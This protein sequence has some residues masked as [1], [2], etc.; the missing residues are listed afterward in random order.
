MTDEKYKMVNNIPADISV[1]RFATVRAQEIVALTTMIENPQ[2]TKLIFQKL[3]CHMRRRAMSHNP[4]RMP[5]ALR[6]AHK[7]Q[8]AKSGPAL[9]P[10]RPRRK[11]RRRPSRLL[12]EY[13]KRSNKI[14]WL[15]TH[16]WHAKRF[17]MTA[18][19]GYRLPEKSCARG[20]RFCYRSVAEHCILL[21]ISY[22][23]CIEIQGPQNAIIDGLAPLCDPKTGTT[24]GASSL[25]NGTR[26]GR[27]TVFQRNSFSRGPIGLV[28]FLWRHGETADMR[29]LWIWCHPAFYEQFLVELK[30]G[31]G[32]DPDSKIQQTK[33]NITLNKGKLNR[34]RLRGP[35]A[36]SVLSNL[37]DKDI[38]KVFI[39]SQTPGFVTGV[40]VRDPRMI[41]PQS[42][43]KEYTS[44]PA[45]C[46]TVMTSGSRLWDASVRDQIAQRRTSF[47]DYVVN[48]RRSQLLVPGSE[49]PIQPEEIP[50]PLLL[51]N[52]S[53]ESCDFVP[54][55]D[56]IIP[57]GWA[58]A[59]WLAL[60]YS[61][62]HAGGLK[63]VESMN[64]E[65]R[66]C[67]D[68]CLEVDSD[69][70]KIA[71]AEQKIKL[72]EEYF[73]RPPKTRINFIKLGTPFP[74]SIDWN[75]L[76]IDWDYQVE[77]SFT[78]LRD[79][80]LLNTLLLKKQNLL[81]ELFFSHSHLVA[82]TIRLTHGSPGD[83][84]MICLPK[85]D[86]KF[87]STINEPIHQDPGA[88]ER[89]ILRQQHSALLKNL[90]KKR[91]ECRRS[92]DNVTDFSS[93]AVIAIHKEKMRSLWLP[94]SC[95]LK[96]SYA[97]PVIGFVTQGDF[98]LSEGKGIGRGYIVISSVSQ[99]SASLVLVRNPGTSLYMW[100]EIAFC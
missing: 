14:S 54:G 64:F 59:F 44:M 31:Y 72:M 97:R 84:A 26:E 8:M 99:I 41:L 70:G 76:L 62:G 78:V 90:A 20:H 85:T 55:C 94:M 86:D 11:Y 1:A 3:P 88:K 56:V 40:D 80:K 28:N 23:C 36:H 16:L 4:N 75:R 50:I 22:L 52:A 89:K 92:D 65:Y 57:A 77:H 67:R 15:E 37:L 82:V 47:P 35:S 6:E 39:A 58:T 46:E 21:D 96:T 95:N 5:R 29:T 38:R 63:D 33:I 66:I 68:L 12:E 79:K 13:K 32:S 48:N 83:F 45:Q 74:F 7:A 24:F 81:S 51:V 91:K 87:N 34:F 71:A 53:Y 27:V 9:K 19:W 43:V 2:T 98:G 18:K 42:R 30:S 49:L 73:R 69:A 60:T 17:H 10:K 100:A 25:L 61:G 93:A